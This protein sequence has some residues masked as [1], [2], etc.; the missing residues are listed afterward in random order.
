VYE[1]DAVNRSIS[2]SFGILQPLVG[3]AF[4]GQK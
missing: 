2:A 4:T 1:F 3:C